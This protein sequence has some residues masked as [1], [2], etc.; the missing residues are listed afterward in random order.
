MIR[1]RRSALIHFLAWSLRLFAIPPPS[2][3]SQFR[4]KPKSFAPTH[5]RYD[6]N[7]TTATSSSH[8]RT[9]AASNNGRISTME[10]FTAPSRYSSV[11]EVESAKRLLVMSSHP[12]LH[13][14]GRRDD[15]ASANTLAVLST[16]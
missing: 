6:T 2:R 1:E 13:S 3:L 5:H 16:E 8:P 11:H 12:N 15:I 14:Y 10:R 9:T 7:T 4:E